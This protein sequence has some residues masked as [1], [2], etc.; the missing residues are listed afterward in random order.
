MALMLLSLLMRM[1]PSP[2]A[3]TAPTL[4]MLR[5]RVTII[6][7]PIRVD[8]IVIVVDSGVVIVER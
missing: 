7:M 4:M 8:D 2:R 5:L 6:T 1:L 3:V